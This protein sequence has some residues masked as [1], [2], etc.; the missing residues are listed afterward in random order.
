MLTAIPGSS[1][2]FCG[3]IIAYSNFVKHKIVGVAL[4]TL[5]RYGAV[6]S[7]TAQEMARGVRKKFRTDLAI[8]VTGIAGPSG[9]TSKKPVGTVY[10]CIAWGKC[11][12][13]EHHLFEGK[14]GQIRKAACTSALEFLRALLLKKLKTDDTKSKNRV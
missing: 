8:A 14:R 5:K 11:I 6:S 1:R 13:V 2:F 10:I 7:Q 9:G 3:G 4:K 12:S